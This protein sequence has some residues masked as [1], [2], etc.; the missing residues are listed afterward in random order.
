MHTFE[1]ISAYPP[2][3]ELQTRPSTH[4]QGIC[5][6]RQ[7]QK[8]GQVSMRVLAMQ[9]TA[10]IM[11]LPSGNRTSEDYIESFPR[12]SFHCIRA[13]FAVEFFMQSKFKSPH[14]PHPNLP[15]QAREGATPSLA[16]RAGE[17]WGGGNKLPQ[18]GSFG[19]RAS[20]ERIVMRRM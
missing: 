14:H 7:S 10:L 8:R 15:P 18:G 4:L 11:T 1:P 9:E 6:E 12:I 13:T 16:Q 2:S 19:K 3:M 5:R 17:G 20:V